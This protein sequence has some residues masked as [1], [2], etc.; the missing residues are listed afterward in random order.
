[1]SDP[2]PAPPPAPASFS[3]EEAVLKLRRLHLFDAL[4]Q[5]EFN[6]V[7][8][9]LKSKQVAAGEALYAQGEANWTMYLARSGRLQARRTDGEGKETVIGAA[10]A[11]RI[12][13]VLP[14]VSR[15]H[16]LETVQAEV[17]SRVWM[18]EHA[19]FEEHARKNPGLMGKLLISD[20]DAR[21]ILRGD[22]MFA[23]LNE[24]ELNML[25]GAIQ[26]VKLDSHAIIY[27]QGDYE[28]G[29]FVV[30]DGA[31]IG[32]RADKA[33]RESLLAMVGPGAAL[34][35]RAFAVGIQCEETVEASTPVTLWKISKD[36]FDAL[37][38]DQHPLREKLALDPEAEAVHQLKK[39]FDW[40]QPDEL[41]LFAGR[42]HVWTFIR[43][44]WP[45]VILLA[46]IAALIFMTAQNSGMAVVFMGLAAALGIGAALYTLWHFIDWRN[47]NYVITDKRVVHRER[48]LF[49]RDEQMQVPVSQVQDVTV[50]RASFT[51]LMFD[52]GDVKVEAQGSKSR[53]VFDEAPHPD[54]IKEAIFHARERSYAMTYAVQRVQ[55]RAEL[56][57]HLGWG[58]APAPLPLPRDFSDNTK[59]G[60]DLVKQDWRRRLG[61]VAKGAKRVRG[62]LMPYQRLEENGQIIYRTHWLELIKNI[63]LPLIGLALI[64]ILFAIFAFKGDVFLAAGLGLA[65]L[66]ALGGLVWQYEDWRND[67]YILA[68][69]RIID[70]VRSPFGLRG[71]QRKEASYA[72][73]QN[74]DATTSGLIDSL[75]NIGKVIVRTAGADNELVFKRVWDPRRVQHDIETR[76][77][78]YKTKQTEKENAKRRNEMADML[79]LYDELRR[80]QRL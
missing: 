44:L 4:N 6:E 5:A 78:E 40:Q 22:P 28:G 27:K 79:G 55:A 65:G 13:N 53:V 47:D 58:S 1:M 9:L 39:K 69:D 62:T 15:C 25:I 8:H 49:L 80:T 63:D 64:G 21:K 32:H 77:N 10:E 38:S 43:R 37:Q 59:S 26:E 60:R 57:T 2:A 54:A 12:F 3:S 74:V 72:V 66:I 31:V 71:T 56:R 42:R 33:G 24:A 34:N 76:V 7:A 36:A 61:A 67:I 68:E 41:I 51:H 14:F 75:F 73:V 45:A 52:M 50:T 70:I 19:D 11:G 29:L 16:T 35:R 30:R 48:I 23:R 46:A 18:I 17:P 20:D